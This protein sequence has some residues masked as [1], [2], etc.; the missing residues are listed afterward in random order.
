MNRIIKN[1]LITFI[2]LA[3]LAIS[4]ISAYS[5]AEVLMLDEIVAMVDD[6]IISRSQ[7]DKR[8][9]ILEKQKNIVLKKP[10]QQEA[11]DQLI[12]E[13]IQLQM[14][15]RAGIKVSDSEINGT[16]ERILRQDNITKSQLNS[17]LVAQGSSLEDFKQQLRND[18]M[19]SQVQRGSLR[20]ETAVNEKEIDDFLSTHGNKNIS[21]TQY[22]LLKFFIK[23][24][25]TPNNVGFIKQLRNSLN[26]GEV[27][28]QAIIQKQRFD[29]TPLQVSD[30]GW[31]SDKKLSKQFLQAAKK[32]KP[33]TFSQA[34]NTG[35][36]TA[37]LL[38]IDKQEQQKVFIDQVKARH[39]LIS[40]NDIRNEQ[41]S[42]ILANSLHKKVTEGG[43]FAQ[44]AKLFSDDKG[45]GS[46]N[47]ELGWSDPR[48]YVPEFRDALAKLKNDEISPVVKT[49]FGWHIIQLLD[50]RK[51]DASEDII[52]NNVRQK[53]YQEKLKGA[54]AD[55][56][57]KIRSEAF[58]QIKI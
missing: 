35:K 48:G 40:P 47:G 56:H 7:L 6:D 30:M 17:R 5:H 46:N 41:A 13:S 52:R 9:S 3:G 22:R 31:V 21:T 18:V 53:L 26:A 58:V 33:R 38:L 2:F 51:H 32:L 19:I 57:K 8:I 39:I 28:L 54:I 27:S 11:L 10:A 37:M 44:L 42:E 49:E 25:T 55:W 50:R 15:K 16:I 29:D 14:A 24:G 12:L 43:D 1:N 4:S 36:G 45:S 23:K 20:K 34:L